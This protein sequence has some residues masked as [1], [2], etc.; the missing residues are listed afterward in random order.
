LFVRNIDGSGE[1][2]VSGIG[3]PFFAEW[4]WS[5]DRVSYLF[6]KLMTRDSQTHVYVYDV[7][8]GDNRSVSIP[9]PKNDFDPEDGPFWSPDDRYL[10]YKT[11]EGGNG[12]TRV[13]I[14]DTTTGKTWRIFPEKA[15]LEDHQWGSSLP[16][17]L[18]LLVDSGGDGFDVATVDPQGRELVLLTDIGTRSV[19]N[20]F[21]RWSPVDDRIVFKSDLEMTRNEHER[22]IEDCWLGSS[23]GTNVMNLTKATTP[24]THKQ[25]DLRYLSWTWDGRWVYSLGSRYDQQ[26]CRITACYRIDPTNGGYEVIL[27]SDPGRTGEYLTLYSAKGSYDGTKIAFLGRRLTVRNWAGDREYERP[28]WVLTLY[29][30]RTEETE[31]LLV[32][33]EQQ[34]RKQMMGEGARFRVEDISWSPDNRS[35]LVTIADIISREDDIIRPDVYRVDLP[36]RWVD[37]NAHHHVG[38]LMGRLASP[39]AT[40]AVS[41]TSDPTATESTT[42]PV[43]EVGQSPATDAPNQEIVTT[44]VSPLHMTVDEAMG[45]L[46]SQYATYITQNVSRNVLLFKGP[47][48]VLDELNHDL[49][50][51]DSVAPHILID[52]IAIELTD[53]ADRELGLDW[54]YV[55]GRFAFIQP[56]GRTS[57]PSG[58]LNGLTIIPG[59]G[60]SFYQGVGSL[61]EEFF[62]RLNTLISDGK[63]TILANPR[64][65]AMSGK[66][67]LINIQKTL[68]FFFNEGFDV[69]GRPIVKKSDISADTEGRI[70][71]TL[72]QDGKIHMVTDVK[73]GTFTF[74]KDAGLPELTTRR[75]TT[76]VTVG[77]GETI[78]IGGLRQQERSEVEVRVPVLSE[79]PLLGRLFKK[80]SR[81]IRNTVLTILITPRILADDMPVPKWPA[82][83][84]NEPGIAGETE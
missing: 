1:K 60:Q 10:A 12:S 40:V 4:S 37:E 71:P 32:F 57:S 53:E 56:E 58:A 18:T 52:L 5:G 45:S 80:Q 74:T 39:T 13:W 27:T 7:A 81:E 77:Q 63:G 59:V 34:D 49:N 3:N 62:V 73:V 55:K 69:A 82:V 51:I 78:I 66:E 64:T 83:D 29:D 65:V 24:V 33:D 76:E 30:V 54:S 75:S 46:P 50:L 6:A 26:G 11:S 42:A 16:P 38:P 25:L 84:V 35:L 21:P 15:S 22:K 36:E 17:R 20:D 67:S 61:P 19:F 47:Q 28:R 9:Y 2:A 72:L 68:N 44:T 8:T 14:V 43:A 48:G 70:T 31:D 23:D 79:I 41:D